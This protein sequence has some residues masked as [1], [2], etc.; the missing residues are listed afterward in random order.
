[1]SETSD[2]TA[3]T[4]PAAK[5]LTWDEFH[6]LVKRAE[7][8]DRKCLPELRDALKSPEYPNWST[9]FRNSHGSPAHWLQGTL[10][11]FG[12]DS[13]LARVEASE[14]KLEELRKDLEGPNP[15]AIE[16][17]LAERAAFCWFIVNLFEMI[18]VAKSQSSMP[19]HQAEF[20]MRRVESANRRFLAAVTSLARVR[21]L[22][23]PT[24]QVNIGNNQVNVATTG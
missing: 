5:K 16:R 12:S 11:R 20:E 7:K 4:E 14:A 15:T 22:A 24:L 23:L 10:A 13:D 17:L 9:W 6:S 2:A 21:K 3:K 19:I 1:M 8:G 18:L